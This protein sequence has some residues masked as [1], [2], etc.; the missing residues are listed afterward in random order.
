MLLN[1]SKAVFSFEN[2]EYDFDANF[3]VN[4]EVF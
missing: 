2:V 1:K 4:V 3:F